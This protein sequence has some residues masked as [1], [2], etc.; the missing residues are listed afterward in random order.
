MKKLLLTTALVAG[1]GFGSFGSIAG[2]QAQTT[3]Y[4]EMPAGVYNLDE[5]HAQLVWQVSHL[6]LSNYTAR[7]TSF[8]ADLTFDP[9]NPENSKLVA[10]IDPTSIKTDFPYPE[11]KDFD[12]ELVSAENWFNSGNFPEIKFMSTGIERTGENTGVLKGDLTF[13]GMTKPMT[14]D[15]TFNA[16]MAQQPFTQK[17]TLGFSARGSIKRS[18]WGMATYVPNIGDEVNLII[19]AEFAMDK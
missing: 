5:T 2:A 10:T 3:P 13:L 16:A 19:E 9:A 8:D 12:A 11:K 17:P 15:V 4:H 7:F 14:L 6:G 1:L 18:E